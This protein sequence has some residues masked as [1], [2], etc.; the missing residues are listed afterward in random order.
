MAP[1]PHERHSEQ[2]AEICQVY[3]QAE[4]TRTE[5]VL[6]VDEMTGIQA[7]KHIANGRPTSRASP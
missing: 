3:R 6:S 5:I 4:D 2:F 1:K 7:L